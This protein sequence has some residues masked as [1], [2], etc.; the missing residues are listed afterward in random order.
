M[1]QTGYRIAML[2]SGAGALI[3]AGRAGWFAAY[4]TIAAL[5]LIGML[6]FLLGPE[7]ST[8]VIPR[9]STDRWDAVRDWLK[10]AVSAPFADLWIVRYGPSSLYSSSAISSAR[11]WR[12]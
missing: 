2:I 3:I 7:P 4:V 5:L 10:T 8:K 6:V 9:L 12:A 1:I 11:R